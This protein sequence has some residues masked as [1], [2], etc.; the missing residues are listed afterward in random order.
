[1]FGRAASNG[2]LVYLGGLLL[3]TILILPPWLMSSMVMPNHYYS[4]PVNFPRDSN[5]LPQ[6]KGVESRLALAQEHFVEYFKQRGYDISIPDPASPQHRPSIDDPALRPAYTAAAF[7][8]LPE[9]MQ[10]CW[11]SEQRWSGATSW[12]NASRVDGPDCA[13]YPAVVHTSSS[14]LEYDHK[15]CHWQKTW[16]QKHA[17]RFGKVYQALVV[18]H[19]LFGIPLVCMSVGLW[20]SDIFHAVGRLASGAAVPSHGGLK[21]RTW[22]GAKRVYTMMWIAHISLALTIAY[23]KMLSQGSDPCNW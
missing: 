7:G 5:V 3:S 16:V 23:T 1:M 12:A 19:V 21:K 22:D 13:A 20:G 10:F 11:P 15:H 2:L 9:W 6:N 14:I 4:A 8:Q 18:L 17:H